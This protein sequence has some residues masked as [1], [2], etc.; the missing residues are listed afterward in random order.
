MAG[1]AMG[2]RLLSGSVSARGEAS[3]FRDGVR[4]DEPESSNNVSSH[5]DEALK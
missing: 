5:H 1:C 4:A 2:Q 3:D